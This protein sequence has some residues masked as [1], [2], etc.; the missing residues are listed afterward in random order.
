MIGGAEEPLYLPGQTGQ[1]AQLFYREDFVAS[2]LHEA[3]HWCIAGAQRRRQVDFGYAYEPPPRTGV[4]QSK[5][6]AAELKTQALEWRF[7]EAAGLDFKASA[8]NLALEVGKEVG[9]DVSMD[10]FTDKLVRAQSS[11]E[12]WLTRTPGTRAQL[13]CQALQALRCEIHGSS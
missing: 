13:F 7:A 12:D 3:A 1:F 5:F 8:D 10:A 6:F 11:V 4:A 2:A 9:K